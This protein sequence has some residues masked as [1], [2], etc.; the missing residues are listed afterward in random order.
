MKKLTP[1]LPSISMFENF[2]ILDIAG[3]NG[4]HHLVNGFLIN[5]GAGWL[6]EDLLVNFPIALRSG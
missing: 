4:N 3:K 6:R 5:Y 1:T 2:L